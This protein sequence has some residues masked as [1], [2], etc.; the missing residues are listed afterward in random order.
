MLSFCFLFVPFAMQKLVHLISP[1]GLFL[2]LL[3]LPWGTD[4]RKHFKVD[5][6]GCFAYVLF[7]EF[8]G[9]WSYV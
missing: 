5:V 3:L 8:D 2:L 1:I 7:G 6:R 4:L 9:V